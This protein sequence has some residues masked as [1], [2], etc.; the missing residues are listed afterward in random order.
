MGAL[1]PAQLAAADAKHSN[2][3]RCRKQPDLL[4]D[5]KEDGGWNLEARAGIEPAHKGFAD[6][7]LTTW[8]PRPFVGGRSKPSGH[9]PRSGMVWSGRRDLNSRP[10]PWQGDALP[11][12][13][14]RFQFSGIAALEECRCSPARGCL[15]KPALLPVLKSFR[16]ILSIPGDP[17]WVKR[18]P[19]LFAQQNFRGLQEVPAERCADPFPRAQFAR[20]A[21]AGCD[22]RSPPPPGCG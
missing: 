5:L 19:K 17:C 10:S 1:L 16:A 6:L 15:L 14:S 7:S 11:L 21:C 12:S 3:E 13:Y 18:R 20:R 2:A 8:V 22:R 9:L 4:I